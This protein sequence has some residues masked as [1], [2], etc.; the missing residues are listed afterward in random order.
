MMIRTDDSLDE[1]LSAKSAKTS[2]I[3]AMKKG[4]PSPQKSTKKPETKSSKSRSKKSIDKTKSPTVQTAPPAPA[5][6][7]L[8]PTSRESC[9]ADPETGLFGEVSENVNSVVFGYEIE[10]APGTTD[11]EIEEEILPAVELDLVNSLLPVLFPEECGPATARNRKQ[12]QLLKNRQAFLRHL[13]G[14]D[15]PPG[16]VFVGISTQ[17]PDTL[18]SD[19]E[20]E[21]QTQDRCDVVLGNMTLYSVEA[22]DS[23]LIQQAI[24]AAKSETVGAI[25]NLIDSDKFD[26]SHYAVEDVRFVFLNGAGT[27]PAPMDFPTQD[28]P[29]MGTP[30]VRTTPV[31]PPVSMPNQAPNGSSPPNGTPTGPNQSPNS[32][33][34]QGPAEQNAVPTDPFGTAGTE[35]D[36]THD[37]GIDLFLILMIATGA[38]MLLS[39]LL[40]ALGCC[41]LKKKKKTKKRGSKRSSK[42]SSVND[43]EENLHENYVDDDDSTF[44]GVHLGLSPNRPS[45]FA[46]NE[47]EAEWDS[48]SN[49]VSESDAQFSSSWDSLPSAM[50]PK[51]A[52]GLESLTGSGTMSSSVENVTSPTSKSKSESGTRLLPVDSHE[53]EDEKSLVP[54]IERTTATANAEQASVAAFDVPSWW[55]QESNVKSIPDHADQGSLRNSE[56]DGDAMKSSSCSGVPK[57]NKGKSLSSQ[58]NEIEKRDNASRSSS[59]LKS[60][61][62]SKE[63]GSVK[64]DT[65]R[66]QTSKGSKQEERS[67]GSS[68]A[69]NESAGQKAKEKIGDS[70][71]KKDDKVARFLS[72]RH[73][74]ERGGEKS[75]KA[76]KQK[77]GRI[78]AQRN[79]SIQSTTATM[80]AGE[81]K[82]SK[83]SKVTDETADVPELPNWWIQA[84]DLTA[85]ATSPV[86]K[87]D[88]LS[89]STEEID[90]SKQP[91]ELEHESSR[92]KEE[93][94]SEPSIVKAV[95][96]GSAPNMTRVETKIE[97]AGCVDSGSKESKHEKVATV[98]SPSQ[99]SDSVSSTSQSNSTLPNWWYTALAA[100]SS[101]TEETN[102]G[103]EAS[104]KK[105]ISQQSSES[106]E[107][108]EA[109][110]NQKKNSKPG[111]SMAVKMKSSKEPKSPSVQKSPSSVVSDKKNMK[112]QEIQDSKD[113]TRGEAPKHMT[114]A[115]TDFKE[116]T[117]PTYTP[118]TPVREKPDSRPAPNAE[119]VKSRHEHGTSPDREEK[120]VNARSPKG[121]SSRSPRGGSYRAKGSKAKGP[122]RSKKRGSLPSWWLDARAE[123]MP[124]I[125]EVEEDGLRRSFDAQDTSSES[126]FNDSA[127]TQSIIAEPNGITDYSGLDN[128][129]GFTGQ[130]RLRPPSPLED[131]SSIE[132]NAKEEALMAPEAVE[133]RADMEKSN[134]DNSDGASK[135]YSCLTRKQP[136]ESSLSSGNLGYSSSSEKL[137]I[138]REVGRSSIVEEHKDT[139]LEIQNKSPS[140]TTEQKDQ[141]STCSSAGKDRAGAPTT[142]ASTT[143]PGEKPSIVARN[144]RTLAGALEQE[145]VGAS[146]SGSSSSTGSSGS[147]GIMIFSDSG[148]SSASQSSTS[149]LGDASKLQDLETEELAVDESESL[150][151]SNSSAFTS[152]DASIPDGVTVMVLTDCEE[153]PPGRKN[154]RSLTKMISDQDSL[155]SEGTSETSTLSGVAVL[156]E[157]KSPPPTERNDAQEV[158][159]RVT[160]DTKGAIFK[161]RSPARVSGLGSPPLEVDES[162]ATSQ[163]GSI[164]CS[165]VKSSPETERRLVLNGGSMED[166]SQSSTGCNVLKGE[167]FR[168]DALPSLPL[169]TRSESPATSGHLEEGAQIQVEDNAADK[170]ME[171]VPPKGSVVLENPAMSKA[172]EPSQSYPMESPYF[173]QEEEKK[174]DD[175]R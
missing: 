29:P 164:S 108:T 118:K 56:Y 67:R 139:S 172:I 19:R 15:P 27:T 38:L 135:D 51:S 122:T 91:L 81:S 159:V 76:T 138:E 162:S 157:P 169:S 171:M 103:D 61:R 32:S 75:D 70:K 43:K 123:I 132:T 131:E 59:K 24:E 146:G 25:K 121:G 48:S 92:F 158:A 173:V 7:T 8:S 86:K 134:K 95:A 31:Q 74:D 35:G 99:G 21:V 77:S 102:S 93:S 79:N 60:E 47:E 66:S 46:A 140:K 133:D 17:P 94:N 149:K 83:E 116:D 120:K 11:E 130:T 2:N 115:G 4:Q 129:L 107:T 16:Q 72:S 87:Q 50:S 166:G 20:C 167:N 10:T 127:D 97:G 73:G 18:L 37:D 128:K 23:I 52:Q 174:E 168:G 147:I 88:D 125:E 112:E 40:F 165:G 62:Q 153:S 96:V 30:T 71:L 64:S 28:P 9:T 14:I 150:D 44:P 106:T 104:T 119:E 13:Q 105:Q 117:S 36:D 124:A 57:S 34:N 45:I 82:Q 78:N 63:R 90:L 109:D 42:Y 65:S 163:G 143:V 3:Y 98:A 22:D 49:I 175:T 80:V 170:D 26:N 156:I 1:V 144:P 85:T 89:K 142:T 54:E 154:C 68:N 84:F 160:P 145:K 113:L 137:L 33:P 155:E 69:G 101:G 5:P 55:V 114:V 148:S 53:D 110:A 58:L 126:P 100:I 141:L 6:V 111:K 39:C 41:C 151:S 12:R 161:S 136:D 152:V